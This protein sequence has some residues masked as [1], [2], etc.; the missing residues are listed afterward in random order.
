MNVSRTIDGQIYFTSLPALVDGG[1]GAANGTGAG[2]IPFDYEL[3]AFSGVGLATGAHSPAGELTLDLGL[4]GWHRLHVAHRP[5]IRMWLDGEEGYCQI[6]GDPSTVRDYAFPAAD[7]TG[8]KLHLAPVRGADV[9]QELIVFYLRAEPGPGTAPIH[10]NLV[11]T[12]DGHGVFCEGLDTPRDF[13]RYLYP[14][15]DSDFFRILWGVYGG[16]PLSM[17][18][19]SAVSELAMQTD[20]HSFYTHD[21][22]FNRSLKRIQAAGAD[23]L[24]VVRQITRE[25]GLELHYYFRVGA[26]YGPFPGLGGTRRLYAEHPEW[27]CRDEFGR[28]VK[29]ISYAF[30]P[31]QDYLLDYFEEL[32]AYEP[33]GLCLAFNRGL[34]LMVCEE[35]VLEAY[36]RKHGRS[37]RLPEEVDHPEM[38]DVRAE[39]LADFLSRVQRLVEAHGKVL[40]CI[41]PRDFVCNRLFGLDMEL[42]I[43]RGLFESVMVGAGHGDD[44]ALNADLEPLRELKALGTA[45]YSGGSS[46]DSHGGAWANRDLRA[47]ARHMAAILDAGLDGGFFWDTDLVVGFEW[48]TMRRFG[49]RAMLDRIIRGEW[50]VSPEHETLAIHDLVVDRYSPWNAH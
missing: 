32:L 27:R 19:D 39:L 36:R 18:P 49:D 15:R 28:E 34:P 25:I 16:G 42:L 30:T 35:P 37:P 22:A 20:D 2:W 7:Y 41:V 23:P 40:S 50:P 29:R 26:F 24:A 43:R 14:Y 44:P 38:L 47:R 9:S 11:A 12:E 8:R 5:S 13:W 17:R 1:F 6:P 31:V 48:E 4:T 45:V 10:R 21:W 46:D 33:D 3:D